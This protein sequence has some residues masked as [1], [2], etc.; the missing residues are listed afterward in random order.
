MEKAG[1]FNP[2]KPRVKGTVFVSSQ[3][4]RAGTMLAALWYTA[5]LESGEPVRTTNATE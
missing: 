3:L 5:W 4:S 1:E 2:D